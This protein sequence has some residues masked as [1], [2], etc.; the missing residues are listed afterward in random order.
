MQELG[1][2]GL[3]RMGVFAHGVQLTK[4]K[5]CLRKW[6]FVRKIQAKGVQNFSFGAK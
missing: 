1:N 5:Q 2:F 6:G 3:E 4:K